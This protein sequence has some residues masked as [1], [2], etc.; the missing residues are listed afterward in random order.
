VLLQVRCNFGQH[1]THPA[2]V[3]EFASRPALVVA[4]AS[5]AASAERGKALCRLS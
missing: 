2:R 3:A 5:C 1:C 4:E